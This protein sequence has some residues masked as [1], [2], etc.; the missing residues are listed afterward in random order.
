MNIQ[1]KKVGRGLSIWQTTWRRIADHVA[2]RFRM[3]SA[4][5]ESLRTH[6]IS[7]LIAAIPFLAGCEN[8]TRVAIS[9]LAV[10]LMSLGTTKQ[11]FNAT[12]EDSADIFARLR[13]ARY[14]G[15]DQAIILRGMSLLALNML[16]DYKRDAEDDTA[17]GKYN[18]IATGDWNYEELHEELMQNILAVDCPQMDEIVTV[19][20]VKD[21]FWN[22]S[23][24]P[25][26][27]F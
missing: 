25:G 12:P 22:N 3:T 2:T 19:E 15:G 5:A 23:S 16:E 14:Q 18:P 13:L 27:F 20:E 11:S 1:S 8:P 26:W 24:F 17:K 21:S 10:Y 4:E 6:N 7:Q 9:N